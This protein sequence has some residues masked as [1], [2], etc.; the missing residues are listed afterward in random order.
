MPSKAG[1]IGAGV[2]LGVGD[3]D[4]EAET[5]IMG[6]TYEH[7]PF[8]WHTPEQQRECTS[9]LPTLHT[10]SYHKQHEPAYVGVNTQARVATLHVSA[11]STN[12]REI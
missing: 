3:M 6:V 11:H 1:L 10:S 4:G 5:E 7:L 12:S 8:V 2:G 9:V